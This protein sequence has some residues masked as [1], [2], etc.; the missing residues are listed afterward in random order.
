MKIGLCSV[1]S[2]R[3]H[4]EQMYYLS[5]LLNDA[6]IETEYIACRGELPACYTRALRP[7]RS[8]LVECALCRI[9]NFESYPGVSAFTLGSENAGF[10][11]KQPLS[12]D[13]VYL[14]WAA[15]SAAT[16]MRFE[17][18]A[19]LETEPFLSMRDG[20]AISAEI[21]YRSAK[22][23]IE[24]KKLEG[25]LVFNGRM[26]ATRGVCEAAKE[27]GVPYIT[28]ERPW[29]GHGIQMLPNESCLGLQSIGGLI[30]QWM[31]QP[32]SKDQGLLGAK[33][34]AERF[35]RRNNRESRA[36]N[37]NAK[38]ISWPDLGG[39]WK[40]LLLP[41]SRNE[42]YGH[43]DWYEEW[44]ER[45]D[46]YDALIARYGLSSRDLVLRA[47]PAWKEKIGS[48]TGERSEIFYRDW[49]A[50]RN[51][52]FIPGDSNIDTLSLIRQSDLVVIHASSAALDAG[53][54]GK[55]VVCLSGTNYRHADFVETARNPQEVENLAP[56]QV[57]QTIKD[58]RRIIRQALRF[59][60]AQTNRI[61]QFV[62]HV[63]CERPTTYHYFVGA[64]AQTILSMLKTG[65]LVPDDATAAE[66]ADE[67]SRVVDLVESENWEAIA[68][69]AR[70]VEPG[71]KVPITRRG[72]YRYIDSIR[73]LLPNGDR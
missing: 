71:P 4:V 26:E 35:L 61:P 72:L 59:C 7:Q 21:S 16:I 51:I 58:K 44:Q 45:T 39:R 48:A 19:E 12:P 53:I 30:K 49:C 33:V 57:T 46:G 69:G 20:F 67:E 27:L 18:G 9:G 32:L 73:Q 40:V 10:H 70:Y 24:R 23:W 5:R 13:D 3:P 29:F 17:T 2:W 60:Y 1:Y 8:K 14:D 64:S 37:V 15:S 25:I 28:I 43:P 36:Y 66:N 62:D 65:Q 41:G 11:G 56:L 50:K 22:A 52:R 38:Q 34:I 55:R 63:R 42:V 6:G 31:G 47:H 54:L 68:G